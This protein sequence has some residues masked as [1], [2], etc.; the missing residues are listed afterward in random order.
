[1]L[2]ALKGK[3]KMAGPKGE[4]SLAADGFFK[5]Y[6]ETALGH[7]EILTEIQIANPSPHTGTAYTKFSLIEGDYAIVSAAVSMTLDANGA[8]S[9]ARVV[10]GAAAPVPMRATRAE[11]L[12]VGKKVDEGLLKKAGQAA[13]EEARPITDIHA[14]EQYRRELVKVLVE[15][16]GKE[17]LARAKKA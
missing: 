8:C 13:S 9:D 5:D 10:L 12:L 16:V 11:K 2:I 1:V 17:A 15:R 7:D 6:F 4:R 14:S 3:L